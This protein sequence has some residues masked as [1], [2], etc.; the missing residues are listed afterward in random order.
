V[1]AAD[2][3]GSALPRHGVDC[4]TWIQSVLARVCSKMELIGLVERSLDGRPSRP[5]QDKVAASPADVTL[6]SAGCGSGKTTAAYLWAARRANGRKLF[7]CYPTTGTATEGYAGYV[8]PDDIPS[9]LI[10]SRAEVDLRD[11]LGTPEDDDRQLRI[12]ALAAWD[13]PLVVCTADTTLGVI[14]N[15]KAGLFAVPAIANGAFV[16]DEVHAY[17]DRMFGALLRFIGAF[18]GAPLL[19]MTAS[20][21]APRLDEIRRL[22]AESRQVFATFEGPSDLEQ[23]SRYRLVRMKLETAW[24]EVVRALASGMRLLWV[25]N[26]VDRAVQL[27]KEVKK[28]GGWPVV[29]YH[30]R[31]RYGDRVR[32]HV[33]VVDAFKGKPESFLAITTQVCEVS[34]DLSADLLITDLAP[35]PAMIQRLGRLNRFVTPEAPGSPR[36]ALVLAPPHPAPYEQSDLHLAD[37]WLARLGPGA[38]SQADLAAAWSALTG[39]DRCEAG[40]S[41]W[42]DGGPVSERRPLREPGATIPVI[43][44]EDADAA[45]HGRAAA[46]RTTIP[47]L[48][49]PVAREWPGWPRLGLARVAPA[50]RIAYSE[51]WGAAW[52]SEP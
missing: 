17:D 47:M 43:R 14:Q 51:D 31:F 2:L 50:G 28:R 24:S 33:A 20:L 12:E 37:Q 27:F 19:L 6:V 1:I 40:G 13:V 45:S 38:L 39:A 42:L 44:S 25:V 8:A 7:F 30:S 48:L 22:C 18:R 32:K 4:D 23:I 36:S 9:A 46:I 52:R 11:I 5:F 49:G 21:Q 16:F 3:A 35:V 26:T 29:V 15:N 10:H 41:A 34:L